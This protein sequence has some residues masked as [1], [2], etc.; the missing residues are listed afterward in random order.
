MAYDKP[1]SLSFKQPADAPALVLASSSRYRRDLLHRL[2]LPFE[3]ISPDVDESALSGEQPEATS[4]R[5]ALA[6]ARTIAA[7]RPGAII[8]GSDQVACLDGEHIGKPG[9]HARAALQLRAMRGRTVRY[10]TALCLI[11]GRDGRVQNDIATVDVT[12]RRLSNT[13]IEAYLLAEQPY[14]VAGSAKCEGLGITLLEAIVSDD[15]T[16]LVGLPLIRLVT[17]LRRVGY[18]ILGTE[19]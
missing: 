1:S 13:E 6:K 2:R 17:M 15:P 11:D 16:A 5:L 3:A 18:P 7:L 12:F 14:D 10:H 4:A 19:L 8:I 9:D